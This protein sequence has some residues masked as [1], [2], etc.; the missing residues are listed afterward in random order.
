MD[1]LDQVFSHQLQTVTA[2]AARYQ[3]VTVLTGKV[4]SSLFPDNV[5][6]IPS[7][8]RPGKRF[9]NAINFL[10]IF[11]QVVQKSKVDLVF[12]HMTDVQS[13][14]IAIPLKILKIPHYLW[15]AHKS[16]S[17]Y[18]RFCSKVVS[19]IISSTAGSIPIDSPKVTL[20]GQ[21][22][23]PNLF[24]PKFDLV[25][26]PVKFIHVGRLDPSK[27]VS[28]IISCIKIVR[29]MNPSIELL[30]VGSPSSE[31][32]VE[33]AKNLVIENEEAIKEGWLRFLPQV[34]RSELSDLLQKSDCFIH[35]F[36][37]SLDKTLVEATVSMLP[38]ISVNHE[39][40]RQ[41]GSWQK[42]NL[43][44][45]LLAELEGLMDKSRAEISSELWRRREKVLTHHSLDI[46]IEKLDEIL[47]R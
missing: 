24:P 32:Y 34:P 18:L 44:I 47:R 7:N 3:R 30:I 28:E 11:F 12:S 39:Y 27:N 26:P 36:R 40:K 15:Y 31:K 17:F 38:V 4:G 20:I 9:K 42:E 2:L 6:V 29:L 25:L 8:W 1:E 45:S 41:F 35:A 37:G 46:W 19:G 21:A 23:D 43:S 13:A 22:I 14:L 5:Q 10:K 16:Q 33:Y